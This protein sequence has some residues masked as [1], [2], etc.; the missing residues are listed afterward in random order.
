MW[1]FLDKNGIEFTANQ[2][3]CGDQTWTIHKTNLFPP[4]RIVASEF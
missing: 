2:E 3:N 1:L 4:L